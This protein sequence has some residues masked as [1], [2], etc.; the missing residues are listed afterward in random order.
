MSHFRVKLTNALHS[1]TQTLC[2]VTRYFIVREWVPV[3]DLY[4]CTLCTHWVSGSVT[5]L[6]SAG[7]LASECT[8]LNPLQPELDQPMICFVP[9]A[10]ALQPSGQTSKSKSGYLR[11]NGWSL[12]VKR[13]L[14]SLK[15]LA[16][17]RINLL[18]VQVQCIL[19]LH[20]KC[21][22][23]LFWGHNNF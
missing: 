13:E 6:C 16:S 15:M 3:A 8:T 10:H 12:C 23:Q 19:T 18:L 17:V 22:R 7:L 20:G 11:R 1:Y 4:C 2:V 5:S 9:P 21:K 14:C